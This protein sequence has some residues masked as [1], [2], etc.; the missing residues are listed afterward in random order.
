MIEQDRLANLQRMFDNFRIAS[1]DGIIAW[2][3]MNTGYAIDTSGLIGA[4][5][6]TG[7]IIPPP[8]IPMGACCID[9]ECSITTESNCMNMGGEYQGDDTG[10]APNPCEGGCPCCHD[11]T[12]ELDISAM[13][14]CDAFIL[15]DGNET[16]S[17]T[18]TQSCEDDIFDSCEDGVDLN[19]ND[20]SNCSACVDSHKC[21]VLSF[22]ISKHCSGTGGIEVVFSAEMGCSNCTADDCDPF[23]CYEE[24]YFINLTGHTVD[25]Y[26]DGLPVGVTTI[27][28]HA[29][30]TGFCGGLIGCSGDMDTGTIDVAATFTIGPLGPCPRG[31][32]CNGTDCTITSEAACEGVYQGD[33]TTCDPNP[34]VTTG[35]CCAFGTC[36]EVEELTCINV[37]GGTFLGVGTSCTPDPC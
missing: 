15:L 19:C 34:C 35:A 24:I 6:A 22:S 13:M 9:G 26:P 2:G 20:P 3:S 21:G 18:F 28:Y 29:D 23:T 1:Q 33:D 10:C 4:V 32:C 25:N 17:H 11:V 8:P 14:M 16:R 37:F 27:N 5:G 12:V 36:F 7:G 31:A 30:R